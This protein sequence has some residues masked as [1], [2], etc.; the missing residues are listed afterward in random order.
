MVKNDERAGVY[1]DRVQ[2][3]KEYAELNDLPEDLQDAMRNHIDLHS[4]VEHTADDKVLAIYPAAL[5]RKVLR[6]LYAKS[7][8]QCYLF[9]KVSRF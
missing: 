3:L 1:R 2:L 7:L 6:H 9:S 5:S 4:Q 8:S